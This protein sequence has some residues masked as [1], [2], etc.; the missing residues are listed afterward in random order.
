[1]AH[2]APYYT[3]NLTTIK[4][5]NIISG[6]LNS[7]KNNRMSTITICDKC[8]KKQNSQNSGHW[9]RVEINARGLKVNGLDN[10]WNT[11]NL[12][13]TCGKKIITKIAALLK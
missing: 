12:C 2:N 1:M 4:E 5:S 10:W 8:N 11:F 13:E 7:L 3:P 9:S 6:A